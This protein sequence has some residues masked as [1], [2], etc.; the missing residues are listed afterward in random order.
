MDIL[1]EKNYEIVLVRDFNIDWC[2]D[3]YRIR[4]VSILNENG[5]KLKVNEFTMITQNSKTLHN[6]PLQ[7]FSQGYG[8]ASSTGMNKNTLIDYIITKM[9]NITAKVN[10]YNK[11]AEHEPNDVLIEVQNECCVPKNGKCCVF[12][13]NKTLRKWMN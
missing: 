2:K 11:V 9:E 5:L 3:Y 12:G 6:W 13:Y 1:C 4:L 10:V 8:L 7:T